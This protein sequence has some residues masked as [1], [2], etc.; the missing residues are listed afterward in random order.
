MDIESIIPDL[1]ERRITNSD[2]INL[3][4]ITLKNI[5]NNAQKEANETKKYEEKLIYTEQ[6]N[7]AFTS[8]IDKLL[9]WLSSN[10]EFNVK[11]QYTSTNPSEAMDFLLRDISTSNYYI[12]PFTLGKNIIYSTI[13]GDPTPF[14]YNSNTLADLYNYICNFSLNGPYKNFPL[15]FLKPSKEEFLSLFWM[16]QIHYSKQKPPF[17]PVLN[18]MPAS[19]YSFRYYACQLLSNKATSLILSQNNTIEK[20]YEAI[21]DLNK[22]IL[23]KLRLFIH[24]QS[25]YNDS[26]QIFKR[27]GETTYTHSEKKYAN[28]ITW[29]YHISNGNIESIN[30]LIEVIAV[31]ILGND[32]SNEIH[33]TNKLTVITT[34]NVN[35][36]STFIKDILCYSTNKP[37]SEAILYSQNRPNYNMC[38]YTEYSLIELD[39]RLTPNHKTCLLTDCL[40]HYSVN[41]STGKVNQHLQNLTSYLAKSSAANGSTC[42]TCACV[43]DNIFNTIRY[44]NNIH[45]VHIID[46][47]DVKS[48]HLLK[49]ME[50]NFIELT[51]DI[52][53][54]EY[55]NFDYYEK[56][57]ISNCAIEGY[58]NKYLTASVPHK[59]NL[60]EPVFIEE[61]AH[62]LSEC[63]EF[64]VQNCF[65]SICPL[66][67]ESTIE[68]A[69]SKELPGMD[70]KKQLT[71]SKYDQFRLNIA[72][73]LEITK[74]PYII[75]SE[76]ID[77]FKKLYNGCTYTSDTE[78]INT[79]FKYLNDPYRL[80]YVKNK[81]SES[82]FPSET[83]SYSNVKVIYGLKFNKNKYE[84]EKLHLEKL[85][86]NKTKSYDQTEFIKFIRTLISDY[87]PESM[88]KMIYD[89][90][91]P[92]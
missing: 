40:F 75:A 83:A 81:K 17:P 70:D 49:E 37:F 74:M 21:E 28:I 59:N 1:N 55:P 84:T 56:F 6:M 85:N 91:L 23:N 48:I 52:S 71:K 79:L 78:I 36:I 58:L 33:P 26:Y 73:T 45:F 54:K 38:P 86:K 46:K 16:H 32:F 15:V 80:R 42:K 39:N 47:N 9:S 72:R 19:I 62:S 31:S 5:F 89:D 43:K 29:L 60:T 27:F 63:M 7:L 41:I 90:K 35:L 44:T 13:L 61:Q 25:S 20:Q 76:F 57:F 22:H 77:I 64:F 8:L 11:I 10:N 92:N 68:S 2:K 82:L 24:P 34:S 50:C 88:Q 66:P 12:L 65:D 87:M 3:I 14:Y 4:N 30:S 18:F 69:I 67:N 51:G 53:N